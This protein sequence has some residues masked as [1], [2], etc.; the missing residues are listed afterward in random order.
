MKNPGMHTR[1]VVP[2]ILLIFATTFVLGAIGIDIATG[3]IENRFKE[4]INLMA[5]YL[6]SNAET[7]LLVGDRFWLKKLAHSLIHEESDIK[8]ISITND[9]GQVILSV[10]KDIPGP[11]ETLDTQVVPRKMINANSFF[12]NEVLKQLENMFNVKPIGT[13]HITYSTYKLQQIRVS[14][15][16]KFFLLM[17]ILAGLGGIVYYFISRSIVREITGLARISQEIAAGNTDLR[18]PSGNIPEV[19]KLT[20]AFNKMLDS[21]KESN[22]ALAAANEKV[23]R[24]RFLAEMGKFSMLIAHEF[25]NPLGIIKGSTD[26]LK[27]DHIDSATRNTMI[28]Y[29]EDEISRLDAL[30]ENFLTFARPSTPVYR[31][32]DANAMLDDIVNRMKLLPEI[33]CKIDADIEKATCTVEADRDLLTRAITNLIRNGC[34]SMVESP[35]VITVSSTHTEKFW[36]VKI[37]DQGTG[38]PDELKEKIFNPFFS[39]KATGCG[40]G[41]AFVH[42]TIKSHKGSI[43]VADNPG[44]GTIFSIKIPLAKTQTATSGHSDQEGNGSTGA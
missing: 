32:V 14:I 34:D 35:G 30:I 3:F 40:L 9:R 18:A 37:S 44:G 6:V 23:A 38:I 20:S 36:M 31:E 26:I 8:S 10:S 5:K 27:K 29:I 43:N 19:Q 39:T 22:L 17:I 4:H 25:K 16:R 13:V 11:F 2:A 24:Q 1:I 28:D 15:T 42:R 21:I 33:T 12:S 7:S 41:L